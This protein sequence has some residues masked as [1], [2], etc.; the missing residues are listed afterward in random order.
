[1][2]IGRSLP[3]QTPFI[4]IFLFALAAIFGAA[5]QFLYKSGAES[6]SGSILSYLNVRIFGGVFCYIA[7]MVLFVAAFRK[8]GRL[9]VL[10]PV[11]ASTFIWASVIALLIYGQ[12]IKPANVFGMLLL[13]L[14][15]YFMGR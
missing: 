14:G 13:V 15:M 5:G 1:M 11:Y 4:S 7:V 10:Y 2:M 9:T 12:P 3:T 6:A 8:G